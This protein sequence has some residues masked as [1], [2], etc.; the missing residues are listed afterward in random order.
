MSESTVLEGTWEEIRKQD[1]ELRGH[2]VRLEV[3]PDPVN[4]Q[5][6][7]SVAKTVAE[8]FAGRIGTMSFEPTDL[9]ERSEEYLAL[10]FGQSSMPESTKK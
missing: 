9:A 7:G 1:A 4:A 3:V 5:A 2:F 8:M 10:G 6:N